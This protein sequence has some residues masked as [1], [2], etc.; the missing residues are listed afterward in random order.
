MAIAI[1]NQEA[2]KLRDDKIE[3]IATFKTIAASLSDDKK[4]R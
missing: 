4:Y 1:E 3:P 2:I